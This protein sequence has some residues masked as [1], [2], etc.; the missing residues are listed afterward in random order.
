MTRVLRLTTLLI[1]AVA[2]PAAAQAAAQSLPRI[3]QLTR[4]EHFTVDPLASASTVVALRDGHV[5]VNDVVGRR[6]LLFDSTLAHPIVVADTTSAT[7]NAYGA[8]PGQLIR[9]RGDS[10]LFIDPSTLSMFVL[11]PTG[12]IARV[13]AVPR[14][15]DA[16]SL[17]SP[18]HTPAVDAQNRL[19]YYDGPIP[20][21]TFW[22]FGPGMPV[23]PEL[24][25]RV[26]TNVDSGAVIGVALDTRQ[27]D[28]LAAVRI[29]RLKTDIVTDAQGGLASIATTPDPVPVIDDWAVLT[30]RSIAIVR[31]RDFHI[32][33]IGAD[34]ARTSTP[35]LA[36]DWQRLDDA[37]KAAL[38]D[39]SVAALQ[40]TMD[41][42]PAARAAGAAANG[43]GRGGSGRGS[44]GAAQPPARTPN[45]SAAGALAPLVAVR[46]AP[47]DVSDY[48]PA[49][50]ITPGF[51]G[52][53][54]VRADADDELWIRTTT[55]VDGRA[56]YDVVD[57]QGQLVDRLQLPAFRTVAGFGPGVVYLAVK[58]TAGAVHVERMRIR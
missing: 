19:V 29:P 41:K 53:G 22:M 46:R 34:G 43:A 55:I 18:A 40:A 31:G 24:R 16:S 52:G 20:S 3:R 2:S 57:R 15:S 47:S 37:R 36:F 54:A 1:A 27:V 5:F 21:P 13:M 30:D 12:A 39:S 35:K 8:R 32:D 38:I 42:I 44:S 14:P 45:P 17:I 33:W 4:V 11:G 48:Q 10:A 51:A 6:V 7:A 9:Y 58:D 50:A 26:N 49:F 56:V 25:R 28:T 23:T